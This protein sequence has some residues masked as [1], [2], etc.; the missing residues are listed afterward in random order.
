MVR[1]LDANQTSSFKFQLSFLFISIHLQHLIEL[2]LIIVEFLRWV[3]SMK[4]LDL[5]WQHYYAL[6][7]YLSLTSILHL[8]LH[9]FFRY[10][11]F[12]IKLHRNSWLRSF[13]LTLLNQR[14]FRIL[15]VRSQPLFG[16]TLN[17]K[18][19]LNP[20]IDLK[21]LKYLHSVDLKTMIL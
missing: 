6:L 12:Q 8:Q 3:Q 7:S 11:S 15:S 19:P 9:L 1:A 18:I 13:S 21:M 16:H 5:D 20:M 14:C 17:Q 10:H 4:V 2:L